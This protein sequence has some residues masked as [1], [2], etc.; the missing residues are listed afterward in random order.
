MQNKYIQ[1]ISQYQALLWKGKKQSITCLEIE[2]TE[3]CDN[4]CVHCYINKAEKDKG[5]A[6]REL[7]TAKLKR[8]ISEAAS[9]GVLLVKFTGGEPLLRADFKELYLFTRKLGLK[10]AL[11]T[12]A[13]FINSDL[14]KLF[15]K[16]PPLIPINISLYGMSSKCHEAI[17]RTPGSYKKVMSGIK[18]LLGADIPFIVA[19]VKLPQNEKE[20]KKLTRW[21]KKLPWSEKN[22]SYTSFILLRCRREKPKNSLIKK[23]RIPVQQYVRSFTRLK[24]FFRDR[25]RFFAQNKRL[26]GNNI[27]N[28]GINGH[29]A[30]LDAYGYLQPCM[31]LRDPD[32]V[33]NLKKGSLQKALTGFF[34]RIFKKISSNPVYLNRCARCFLK[35]ICEQCPG[36]SWI[37]HGNLD[38]PVDYCCQIT[39]YEARTLGLLKDNECAWNVP[40]WKA[41]LKKILK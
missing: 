35:C 10:V 38:T 26:L 7:S 9:L 39:H 24:D 19:T 27:F 8:I 30:C 17:T 4:N 16:V 2:L 18:R 3:R 29:T 22:A 40:D 14:I 13:N 33:Y 6:K 41:R 37:E 11:F 32:C 28:C 23:L 15:R 36:K 34:P 1:K 20:F 31:L 12:N 5:A 25:Q 21:I